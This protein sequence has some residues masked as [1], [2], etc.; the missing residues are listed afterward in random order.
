MWKDWPQAKRL[1]AN[2]TR[3]PSKLRINVR[4]Q[5]ARKRGHLIRI[6]KRGHV[7][8]DEEHKTPAP[9]KTSKLPRPISDSGASH[10]NTCDPNI[11]DQLQENHHQVKHVGGY[12][13]P[14]QT[15][16]AT[17]EIASPTGNNALI[18]KDSFFDTSLRTQIIS[19][20][21]AAD[22]HII[23]KH[24]DVHLS[25]RAAG[26]DRSSLPQKQQHL[27]LR[28]GQ[29]W[30]MPNLLET[31]RET[32]FTKTHIGSKSNHPRRQTTQQRHEPLHIHVCRRRHITITRHTRNRIC[33]LWMSQKQ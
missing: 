32:N 22:S 13:K 5:R 12:T 23:I 20:G 26:R 21:Q 3:C 16:T 28:H 8:N 2:R 7:A 18:C 14:E 33:T 6:Y 29:R 27:S 9:T 1:Q 19:E 30:T 4:G 24:K 15:C 10:G 25:Q 31:R 17:W 11:V